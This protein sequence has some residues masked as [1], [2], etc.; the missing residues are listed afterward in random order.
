MLD[1]LLELPTLRDLAGYDG[2][3]AAQ[4]AAKRATSELVGRLRPRAAVAATRAVARCRSARPLRGVARRARG[5]A[6][7]CALLKAIAAH[8]V[9]ARPGAVQRQAGQR[10]VLTEL[11]EALADRRRAR[12]IPRS[13]RPGTPRPATPRD[14][15]SSSIRSRN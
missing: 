13:S 2:T 12:S 8:Y 3:S 5:V 1:A 4:A 14:C 6:A 7:E 10:Q 11:V 15:A 9:M